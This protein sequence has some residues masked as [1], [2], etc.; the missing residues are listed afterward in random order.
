MLSVCVNISGFD[1]GRPV[2]SAS[3]GAA[4]SAAAATGCR[5]RRDDLFGDNRCN[6][7]RGI[8]LFG[9]HGHLGDCFGNQ[10]I[11]VLTAQTRHIRRA[12][13]LPSAP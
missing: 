7:V 3:T 2:A 6:P 10:V 8:F 5:R 11:D 12:L 4:V 1:R 13:E 9:V